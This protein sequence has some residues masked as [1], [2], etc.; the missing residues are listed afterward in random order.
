VNQRGFAGGVLA[1]GVYGFDRW[2]GGPGSCTLNRAADGTVTLTGALDQVIDV[3]HA[4]A[5]T[6]AADLAGATLTLSVQD[7]S[8]P[9][10]VMIGTKPA[11]IPAGSGRCSATVTLDP[12]ETGHVTIRFNPS[13]ACSFRHAKL[14][15]GSFATSWVGEPPDSEEMRCRRYYQPL[16]FSGASPLI[17]GSLGQRIAGTLIEIPLSLP[18]PM[19][20]SP[21]VVTSGPIWATTSPLG[22]QIA[23]YNNSSLSW[24]SLTGALSITTN[25]SPNPSAAVLRLVAGSAFSGSTGAVGS[26]QLGSAAFMALQAEL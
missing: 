8:A 13:S 20:A 3:A 17:L 2:K 7:P 24:V 9:L 23:F 5:L 11:T 12:S 15:I 26:L 25:G 1:E 6:G 4:S 19:R 14:E 21:I 10:P 22:N 16:P 18:V